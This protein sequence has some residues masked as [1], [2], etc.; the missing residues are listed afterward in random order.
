MTGQLDAL[1]RHLRVAGTPLLAL[2]GYL[3]LLRLGPLSGAE[4]SRELGLDRSEGYR[5]SRTLRGLGLGEGKGRPLLVSAKGPDRVLAAL[6]EQAR[7]RRDRL[8]RLLVRMEREEG[9]QGFGPWDFQRARPLRLVEGERKVTEAFEGIMELAQHRVDSFLYIEGV[10]GPANFARLRAAARARAR[11]VRFRA[12]VEVTPD[13]LP[14]FERASALGGMR[15]V[16]GLRYTRYYVIDGKGVLVL[17]L[18]LSRGPRSRREVALWV[19]SP[20]VV[21][22]YAMNFEQMFRGG[23]PLSQRVRELRRGFPRRVPLAPREMGSSLDRLQAALGLLGTVWG[24]GGKALD[25]GPSL[26]RLGSELGASLARPTRTGAPP[27]LPQTWRRRRLGRLRWSEGREIRVRWE[28]CR[29]CGPGGFPVSFCEQ[30]LRGAVRASLG[31]GWGLRSVSPR[32]PPR[33][34]V[35]VLWA[36]RIPPAERSPHVRRRSGAVVGLVRTPVTVPNE[37]Y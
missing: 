32:D 7:A 9:R 10:A 8:A 26:E 34:G 20:E 14:F 4:L 24:G 22:F 13:N 18:P 5:L 36:E 6:E 25:L 35:H 17:L 23:L 15:H 21:R 19:T 12:V 11:G 31:P 2:R 28:A 1:E 30:L 33:K 29:I 3:T 37:Q 27:H 16:P